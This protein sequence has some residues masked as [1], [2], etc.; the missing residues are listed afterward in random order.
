MR[1]DSRRRGP[2]WAVVFGLL[3]ILV[4][5]IKH[6]RT[7][8]RFVGRISIKASGRLPEERYLGVA[9]AACSRAVTTN[10]PVPRGLRCCAQQLADT[11]IL[12]EA[13]QHAW[14]GT[15]SL[16]STIFSVLGWLPEIVRFDAATSLWLGLQ[17]L[18]LAFLNRHSDART[19]GATSVRAP[20]SAQHRSQQL[21]HRSSRLTIG[22]APLRAISPNAVRWHASRRHAQRWPQRS[23]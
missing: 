22:R 16:I 11:H 8:N 19:C 23:R 10:S 15:C 13:D 21:R 9:N 12:N 1:F 18:W 14:V 7:N 3:Q 2:S 6:N 20:P 5:P 4:L 17:P